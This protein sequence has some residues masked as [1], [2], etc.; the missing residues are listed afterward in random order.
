MG[1]LITD[2]WKNSGFRLVFLSWTAGIIVL[3]Y[4][5]FKLL[6]NFSLLG[7]AGLLVLLG[8][9]LGIIHVVTTYCTIRIEE[10]NFYIQFRLGQVIGVCPSGWYAR[11]PLIDKFMAEDIKV[12]TTNPIEETVFTA[13]NVPVKFRGTVLW[14]IWLEEDKTATD[15]KLIKL[16]LTSKGK[17]QEFITQITISIVRQAVLSMTYDEYMSDRGSL[18]K[19]LIERV[20]Y[21]MNEESVSINFHDPKVLALH[22][23]LKITEADLHSNTSLKELAGIRVVRFNVE[24]LEPAEGILEAEQRKRVA[25]INAEV[26]AAEGEAAAKKAIGEGA[27]LVTRETAAGQAAE[28]RAGHEATATRIRGQAAA[29]AH[30]AMLDADIRAQRSREE[31]RTDNLLKRKDAGIGDIPL[32]VAEVAAE[33]SAAI[34]NLKG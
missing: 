1:K 26:A 28:A 24:D 22:A 33:I 30:A 12:Q 6:N 27:A 25:K 19:L 16:Y 3:L 18:I 21:L 20:N 11:V 5:S 2:V 17:I 23:R 14:Q 10:P 15:P 29:D 4:A 34:K 13:D 31:I 9:I 32:A 8:A 7:L